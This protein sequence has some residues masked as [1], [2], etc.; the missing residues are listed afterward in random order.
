MSKN[1]ELIDK[2]IE[3]LEPIAAT[4]S[5]WAAGWKL[6]L[7]L[8]A[9]VHANNETKIQEEVEAFRWSV[10]QMFQTIASMYKVLVEYGMVPDLEEENDEQ[11]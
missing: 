3:A 6:R 5:M 1:L 11:G 7:Q 9:T 8:A 2:A 4:G 10:G